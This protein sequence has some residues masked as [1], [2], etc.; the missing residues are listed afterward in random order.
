MVRIDTTQIFNMQ[1]HAG[2][3]DQPLEKLVNEINI[4][5]TNHCPRKG[6]I[7]FQPR[8]AGKVDHDARQGLVKRNVAMA[9]TGQSLFVTPGL[10][11]RLPDGDTD[12]LHRVMRIDMEIAIGLHI[13]IDQ[14][15]TGNL[16]EHV[17]EERYA[18][19]KLALTGAIKIETHGNLR[20]QRIACDFSLPHGSL[21]KGLQKSFK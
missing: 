21:K 2:M 6:D 17:V 15:M 12:I 16:V 19:G 3:I 13:K 10:G 1:G 20:L 8:P 4:E 9:I 11:Q 18:S 5:L 14:A 7:E